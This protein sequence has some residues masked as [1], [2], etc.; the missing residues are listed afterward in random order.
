MSRDVL[1]SQKS[2]I[3]NAMKSMH[4]VRGA[5]ATAR[6]LARQVRPISP[7]DS[8]HYTRIDLLCSTMILS[9]GNTSF[10]PADGAMIL[11][12]IK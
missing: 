1:K 8:T 4:S 9:M 12:M 2:V 7:C 3:I 10:S 5:K 11:H 6:V